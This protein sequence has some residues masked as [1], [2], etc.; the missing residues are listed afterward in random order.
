MQNYDAWVTREPPWYNS[1]DET[2]EH[3]SVCGAFLSSLPTSWESKY[4]TWVC[5]GQ[6]DARFGLTPC[7]GQVSSCPGTEHVVEV[8]DGTSEHFVCSLC[9]TDNVRME[10]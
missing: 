5:S 6:R 8:Y 10:H 3:C 9:G 4:Q 7:D 2:M 1:D